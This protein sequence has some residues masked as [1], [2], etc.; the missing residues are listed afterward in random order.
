L[1]AFLNV[2]LNEAVFP[3]A[4]AMVFLPAILKSCLIMPLFVTLKVVMP[5]ATVLFDSVNLNSVGL[6]AVTATVVASVELL[7]PKAETAAT[8]ATTAIRTT[9]ADPFRNMLKKPSS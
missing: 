1:P 8:S 3:V 4:R 6:P 5:F 9:S 7:P 2:T